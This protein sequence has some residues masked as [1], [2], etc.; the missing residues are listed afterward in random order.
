L[1][2]LWILLLLLKERG[3]KL[4]AFARK[5]GNREMKVSMQVMASYPFRE[6]TKKVFEEQDDDDYDDEE[7]PETM[8]EKVK[9][10]SPRQSILEMENRCAKLRLQKLEMMKLNIVVGKAQMT[11]LAE[12]SME[13]KFSLME[14]KEP[15]E[16]EFR[17]KK[18]EGWDVPARCKGKVVFS[19]LK[20]DLHIEDLEK[21]L[22][23]REDM[24]AVPKTNFTILK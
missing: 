1:T 16:I 7:H 8:T 14:N 3:V 20:K 18:F 9:R 10:L 17:C 6:F 11:Y 23:H 15:G 21:E 5:T 24:P 19:K 22:Q 12:R 2:K 4:G 13:K